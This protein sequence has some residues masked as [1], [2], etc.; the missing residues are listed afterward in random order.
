MIAH[1]EDGFNELAAVGVLSVIAMR[2]LLPD[3]KLPET[4]FEQ[5]REYTVELLVPSDNPY[6]GQ[7]LGEAGL[8]HVKGGCLFCGHLHHR[9][10]LEHGG[11]SHV[12]PYHVRGGIE[13]GL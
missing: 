7:T 4:A 1:D 3:R 6:I 8:L 10:H 5:T 12:L 13:V 9:I 11:G 2:K